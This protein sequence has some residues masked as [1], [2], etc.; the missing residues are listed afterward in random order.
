[1]VSYAQIH[2]EL[3]IRSTR[4]LE[5]VVIETIYAGLVGG[6][7]DQQKAVFHVSSTAGR[8]LS[9]LALI[10]VRRRAAW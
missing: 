5:D 4:E 8:A 2:E 3:E 7:M 9:S 6:K 10:A 1:M